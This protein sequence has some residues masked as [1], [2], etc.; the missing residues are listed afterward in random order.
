MNQ[1]TKSRAHTSALVGDV[2]KLLVL[3]KQTPACASSHT[4]TP[5]NHNPNL[6]LLITT[7]S[8]GSSV[9]MCHPSIE[10]R[11]KLR[12]QRGVPSKAWGGRGGAAY[13]F[14]IFCKHKH[15]DCLIA[16]PIVEFV[17]RNDTRES[18]FSKL[19]LNVRYYAV[20]KTF[21]QKKVSPQ[22]SNF[23]RTLIFFGADLSP[24]R[25]TKSPPLPPNFIK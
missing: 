9:A 8:D 14:P 16:W 10:Q 4:V 23:A 11:R 19:L 15:G 24:N 3:N 6:S 25:R 20:I 17:S 5:P 7:K 1:W 12:G 2:A 18:L 13:I 21:F 22:N